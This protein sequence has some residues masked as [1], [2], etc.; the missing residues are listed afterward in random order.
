MESKI[1][2]MLSL[3]VVA[4]MYAFFVATVSQL[5]TASRWP[6]AIGV[7]IAII[8]RELLVDTVDWLAQRM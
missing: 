3:L 7:V 5:F 6:F 2:W 4:T 1:K 8:F